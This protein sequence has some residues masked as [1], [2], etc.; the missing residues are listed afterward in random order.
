M[1]RNPW[2]HPYY[3][4]LVE[5]AGFEKAMDLFMWELDIADRGR[6]LP[7][8]FELAETL[9]PEHGIRIRHW[10]KRRLEREVSAFVEIYNEAWKDNWGFCPINEREAQ[11]NYKQLKPLLDTNWLMAAEKLDDGE[12]VGVALTF[13]DYNRMLRRARGR[14]LPIG[15]LHLLRGWRRIDAVRVG[16]LGVKPEYQHTGVAAGFYAEHFDMAAVTRQHWGEMGWILESNEAMNRAMEAMGGR[17]VK[18]FRLYEK[19]L[20]ER[21]RAEE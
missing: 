7:V 2:Q 21:R 12:C 17:I 10:D 20:G 15:W 9:E 13:P 11:H 1:V 18:R 8:I 19:P 5:A 4:G 3:R 14:L 16:F 6:V